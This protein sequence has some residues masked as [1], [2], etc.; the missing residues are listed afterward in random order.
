MSVREPWHLSTDH[1]RDYLAGTANRAQVASVEAHLLTCERCR[2]A[3]AATAEPDPLEAAWAR[4]AEDLDRP[5]GRL[6]PRL[7]RGNRLLRASLATP[8]MVGAALAAVLLVGAVPLLTA[9]ATPR[10]GLTTLLVVAPLAPSLAVALAYR[11]WA[12][13][14]GELAAATP[15]AGLRLVALRALAVSLVALPLSLV[16]L[17]AVDAWLTPVPLR[18]G[19][20]WCLPGLALAALVLLAGTTRLDPWVATGVLGVGWALAVITTVTVQRT[21]RPEQ[22]LD[23]LATPEVQGLALTVATAAL[24]LTAA[25]RH[26]VVTWRSA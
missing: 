7:A 16:V 5:S 23:A 10:A 12:D 1:L 9:F 15:M 2:S 25:R 11:E 18:F 21:I 4:L 8:A 24:L 17:L 13:P 19:L 6:L 22:F 26:T 20:A 3:V 14:A